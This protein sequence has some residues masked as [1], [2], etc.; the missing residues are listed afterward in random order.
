MILPIT[1]KAISKEFP[2][3]PSYKIILLASYVNFEDEIVSK[4]TIGDF[5]NKKFYF[6]SNFI[7]PDLCDWEITHWTYSEASIVNMAAEQKSDFKKNFGMFKTDVNHKIS[8]PVKYIE[9]LIKERKTYKDIG[10]FDA[11]DRVKIF[12]QQ[13]GIILEDYKNRTIWRKNK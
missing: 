11:A 1:F 5:Y 2:S 4:L 9:C 3:D 12:L 6:Y 8:M 10:D 7:D 13:K